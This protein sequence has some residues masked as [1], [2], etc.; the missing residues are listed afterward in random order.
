LSSPENSKTPSVLRTSTQLVP[1][2]RKLIEGTP[3]GVAPLW[4]AG[5]GFDLGT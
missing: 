5:L 3:A 1:V 4:A 2:V